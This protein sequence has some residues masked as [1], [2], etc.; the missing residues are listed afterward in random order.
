[1]K[2]TRPFSEKTIQKTCNF[3]NEMISMNP[4]NNS[5]HELIR[6]KYKINSNIFYSAVASG[7]LTKNGTAYKSNVKVFEPKHCREILEYNKQYHNNWLMKSEKG[8]KHLKNQEV[9]SDVKAEP[10]IT[11]KQADENAITSTIGVEMHKVAEKPYVAPIKPTKKKL[12]ILWGLFKL[13]Y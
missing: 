7:Y 2:N 9:V 8:K 3:L 12:S 6:N 10:T 11:K 5:A 4:I 13:E 1:M